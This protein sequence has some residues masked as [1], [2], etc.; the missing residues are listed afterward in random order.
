MLSLAVLTQMEHKKQSVKKQSVSIHLYVIFQWNSF[1]LVSMDCSV[2]IN[3][4]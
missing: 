4:L 3:T 2:E 1:F